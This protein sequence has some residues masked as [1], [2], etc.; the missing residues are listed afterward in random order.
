MS[1]RLHLSCGRCVFALVAFFMALNVSRQFAMAGTNDA[2]GQIVFNRDI[3]PILSNNCFQCHG[4][5]RIQR[6]AEL[7]L[8][9]EAGALA[10]LAS[11]AGSTI[12][13][14]DSAAS[15]LME[16]VTST[17]ESL[18]M[19]P[20]ETGKKL[21]P[22]QIETLRA[23]IDGGAGWQKHWSFLKPERPDVPAVGNAAW[24]RNPIDHFVLQRLEAEK[25]T[26]SPE[27]DKE[28]LIRRV[29]L[30][31][32]GLPPTLEEIDA[33][34][35]DTSADAYEKVVDRLLASPRYGENMAR[36]WLDAARYGDTHGLHLDNERSMWR[37]RDWVINAFNGNQP[38]DQF[39]VEQ[40]AGDL[41]PSPTLEQRVATGFNRCNITTGEGGSID[42]E[43]YVRYAVDR[44]ETTSTV[45]MGLTLGCCVCHDHKYDPLSQREFYQ[46]FA[47]FNSQ[48]EKAMD[49]NAL[50]PPPSIKAP[51]PAQSERMAELDALVLA[52]E[53][54]LD[55]PLPEVDAAQAAWEAEMPAKL[56]AQWQALSPRE[57]KSSGGASLRSLDDGT[58][59]AEGTNPAKD[60]YEIVA[61]TDAVGITAIKL[62]ALADDS[63]VGRGPGRSDNGNFV[64]SEIEVEAVAVDNPKAVKRIKLVYAQADHEQATGEYFVEKAI[65]SVVDDQNGWA[66]EGMNRHENRAAMFVASEPFGFAGGT[67]VRIRLRHETQFPQHA[68]GRFKLSVSS[69]PSLAPARWSDWNLLGPFTAAGTNE[70]FENDFGPETGVD[71]T[72]TYGEDKKAWQKKPEFV[73][74]QEHG[75][76]GDLT[77]HY[78]YRTVNAPTARRVTLSL[79]SDDG[80]KLWINDDL[81]LTKSEVRL[82]APDSDIV[83]VD[84]PAGES[85]ILMKVVNFNGGYGFYFRPAK[86]DAGDEALQL[87]PLLV[88]AA[89]QRTPEQQKLVRNYFRRM[90]S[91]EWQQT[92]DEMA[93]LRQQKRDVEAQ[94]PDTLVMEELPEA[95][96]AFILVRGQ[97]DKKGDPVVRDVP[98]VLP[99]LP[100][101]TKPDRLALARW[102]VDPE[103]PLTARVTVNRFWQQYFGTGI[104][105]T[106]EDFGFQG[107]WP[108][109]PA[110][111]DWLASEFVTSGWNVKAMQRL[112]V[113]SAAYRQSSHVTPELLQ[114]D[115]E[116]RLFTRGPRFR[117]EAEAIRDHALF[118]SGLLLEQIGGV[119]SVKPY[120]PPGLWEAVGFTSSNTAVFKQD[121]GGALYR[122]SMYT[123][124]KRTSPPPAMLIFDAPTRE[125]CTV[126]RARTNTPLQALTLMN[127]IQFV[128]AA[129]NLATRI[130][131]QGGG[132]TE[133]RI[134][135]AFRIST[136]RQPTDEEIAVLRDV[137]QQQL[138]EYQA[139]P[140][141]AMKLI[142]LGESPRPEH[143]DASEL[144]AWTMVANLILNLDESVTNG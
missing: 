61:E 55:A 132:T 94:V 64:L 91:P 59:L 93:G 138:A 71:L 76:P 17:D 134:A 108:S 2:P 16:R 100:E 50:A 29:T 69:D 15:I 99:P 102:L 92:Q 87:A 10:P 35:A 123:F 63:L 19:P 30:H 96:E 101:G 44:V 125:A 82:L 52:A 107:E 20:P 135:F 114:H 23:W 74:G 7:R 109:H 118:T 104:V 88:L 112:I 139:A 129:R 57:L 53:Q 126:R 111:L 116:N 75:L 110:L 137:Y 14:G 133:E 65:D 142:S 143:A 45:F 141:A 24:P 34:L 106:A 46:M 54:R 18:V 48:T 66:V 26:P 21:T 67:L 41:L 131:L 95:K 13:P 70:V 140:E 8:D 79:G 12:V 56:Q 27:A 37:Y 103:Q 32:T 36:Y 83:T 127:D 128:E 49:G 117:L 85:R 43:Y 68:I 105:K 1:C 40:L 84:L 113:T 90:N 77:T 144:A 120:Q 124:W 25:L 86:E 62:D 89:D 11:G 136:S 6:Q 119:R 42:E 33:F 38:F 58:V 115:R 5:D 80:I 122:R 39:T 72:A 81:L 28:T 130:L 4:P 31:L 78:L 98:A 121:H 22:E 9:Q 60:T 97:Y 3:R 51:T 73:D 47:F